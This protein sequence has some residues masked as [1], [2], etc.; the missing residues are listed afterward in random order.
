[1]T[2]QNAESAAVLALRKKKILGSFRG[3]I[4]CSGPSNLR[5]APPFMEA[6]GSKADPPA[7]QYV[8]VNPISVCLC[9]ALSMD[10]MSTCLQVFMRTALL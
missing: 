5:L 10:Y 9:V 8:P 7:P 4:F 2:R 6:Q 3:K 1:M